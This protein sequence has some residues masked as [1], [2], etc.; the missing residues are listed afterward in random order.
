[1]ALPI[2]ARLRD[3]ETAAWTARRMEYDREGVESEERDGSGST[4]RG[5]WIS[6]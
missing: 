5:A 4:S 1:M 6:C 2:V 3:E